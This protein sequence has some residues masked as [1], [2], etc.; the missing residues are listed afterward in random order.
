MKKSILK[1]LESK[2]QG[3]IFSSK[4]F[5]EF[6]SVDASSYKILPKIIVIP[7]N[8]KHVINVVKIAKKIRM[9]VTVRGAGTGLVGG[10][11]NSGIILDMKNF[12]SIKRIYCCSLSRYFGD[13]LY[14]IYS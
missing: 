12:N 2:I 6:Y 7:K 13:G 3:E 14:C 8:E 9:S 1:K 4:E 5:R 10:A 11:L